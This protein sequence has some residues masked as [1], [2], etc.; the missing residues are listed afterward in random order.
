MYVVNY[1]FL[2]SGAENEIYRKELPENFIGKTYEYIAKLCF[3]RHELLLIAIDDYS[4]EKY[5][6]L[7]S[8]F[9][10]VLRSG[11]YGYFVAKNDKC[12]SDALKFLGTEFLHAPDSMTA[13][14]PL[15]R[16][17]VSTTS[18]RQQNV[19]PVQS[20]L[21]LNPFHS[22]FHNPAHYYHCL[23]RDFQ[24]ALVKK[25]TVK[26]HIILC[27]FCLK[28]S[29]KLGLYSF[30]S[31]LRVRS[32]KKHELK[33]IVII[34]NKDCIQRNWYQI[35]EFDQVF[36]INGN[37]LDKETLT[38]ANVA[39]CSSCVILGSTASLDVDPAL[40]DKQPILC[41]F[42]LTSY[43]FNCVMQTDWIKSGKHI[44]KITELY[45]EENVRFLDLNH[46]GS[47]SYITSQPFA[48][49]ECISNTVFDALVAVTYF[50]PGINFLFAMLAT[51]ENYTTLCDNLEHSYRPK[52]LQISLQEENYKRFKGLNFSELFAYLLEEKMLCVGINRVMENQTNGKHLK[53]YV[54]SSPHNLPLQPNDNIFVLISK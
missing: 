27:S 33:P 7:P 22:P 15:H 20:Q 5:F 37:P 36:V 43:S 19:L 28:E 11:T 9:G 2:Y 3:V 1:L 54:I 8:P 29:D 49:G 30:V 25:A 39:Q 45:K 10:Y 14:Q 50:N 21:N 13:M 38:A 17:S 47:R 44:N 12:V 35:S 23:E 34:G 6:T 16:I 53:R 32:L 41:S 26:D 42:T 48:L 18:E 52:F 24:V 4:Q 40:I 31:P 46:K 51:G